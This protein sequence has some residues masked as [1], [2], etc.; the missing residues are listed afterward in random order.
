[1]MDEGGGDLETT[2]V[3]ALR[4]DVRLFSLLLRRG[5]G[6]KGISWGRKS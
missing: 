3:N 4:F 2:L 6:A 1:M 5:E